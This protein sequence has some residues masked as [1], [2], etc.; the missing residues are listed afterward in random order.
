MPVSARNG[1]GFITQQFPV[2]KV[3]GGINVVV[4]N[5]GV[6]ISVVAAGTVRLAQILYRVDLA[7]DVPVGTA[8]V[9]VLWRLFVVIGTLPPDLSAFQAQAFPAGSHPEVPLLTAAGSPLQIL[10]DEWLDFSNGDPGLNQIAQVQLPDGGPTVN[11]NDQLNVIL[12]PIIDANLPA[13]PLGAA[14]AVVSLA[15][16]GTGA[17][18]LLGGIG[19]PDSAASLPRYATAG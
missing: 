10:H 3:A 1:W 6:A 2:T 9:P 5:V 7:P 14:N 19:A 12:M 4:S 8:S 18:S 16:W 17:G 13:A 15:A 11:K